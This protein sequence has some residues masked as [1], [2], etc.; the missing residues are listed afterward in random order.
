M[1]PMPW[2]M[3]RLQDR[4]LVRN[5]YRDA[6]ACDGERSAVKCRGRSFNHT[7]ECN[8][9]QDDFRGTTS[10]DEN[11]A[12]EWDIVC[13]GSVDWNNFSVAWSECDC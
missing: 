11:V 4:K 5:Q 6:K 2:S 3:V 1:N 9:K 8:E 10:Q 13:V 7:P 12:F